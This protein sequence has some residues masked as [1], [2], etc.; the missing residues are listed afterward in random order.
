MTTH[1]RHRLRA[2]AVATLVALGGA[3]L[4]LLLTFAFPSFGMPQP[5]YGIL[6]IPPQAFFV[7]V[8]APTAL[9]LACITSVSGLRQSRQA[10]QSGWA[11]AFIVLLLLLLLGPAYLLC[12]FGVGWSVFSHPPVFPTLQDLGWQAEAWWLLAGGSAAVMALAAACTLVYA[13]RPISPKRPLQGEDS[14]GH[15]D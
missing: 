5:F 2:L 3:L 12:S 13:S 9:A 4:G 1:H 8:L 10:G 15:L 11:G 7:V 6:Y 14:P